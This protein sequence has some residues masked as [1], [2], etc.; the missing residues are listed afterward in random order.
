MVKQEIQP[1]A[2]E[3]AKT[4]TRDRVTHE[5][6]VMS[7]AADGSATVGACYWPIYRHHL[8]ANQSAV[9]V[10]TRYCTALE[11]DAAAEGEVL[12]LNLEIGFFI[13][14]ATASVLHKQFC[15]IYPVR[16]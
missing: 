10:Y 5:T 3:R 6:A 16:K 2:G 7:G 9:A 1:N 13:I 11:S 12:R 14:Y 8:P 15:I 4:N